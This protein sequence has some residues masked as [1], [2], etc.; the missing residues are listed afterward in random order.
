MNPVN[1]SQPVNP[2]NQAPVSPVL[3]V[4][5]APEQVG[6]PVPKTQKRFLL[7][8][9]LLGLFVVSLVGVAAFYM[10]FAPKSNNQVAVVPTQAP[11]GTSE[12][13]PVEVAQVEQVGDLDNLIVGL[14]QA[15]GSLDQELAALQKDSEF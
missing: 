10:M 2:V 5:P 3:P 9:V 15:D 8:G 12:P 14:A 13:T 7:Y 11:V 6:N 1:N 4:S